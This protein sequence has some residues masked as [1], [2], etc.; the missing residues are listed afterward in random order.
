[1]YVR[2]ARVYRYGEWADTWF[3]DTERDIIFVRDM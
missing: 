3:W 2:I 1:M